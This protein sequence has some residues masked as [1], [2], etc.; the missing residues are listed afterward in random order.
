VNLRVIGC[1]GSRLEES[2]L[3]TMLLGHRVMLDAGSACSVPPGIQ[4]GLDM[5]LLTHAHLDHIL[6]LG[7]LL[8]NV[9]GFRNRPLTV[10]GSRACISIIR[11]HYMNDRLWP[12]FSRISTDGGPVLQY[13]EMPDLEWFQ[14]PEGI[15]AMSVPVNHPAGAR[16]FIFRSRNA[17]MAYS[18]DTG[19]TE[20]IWRRAAEIPELCMAWV[21]C[22]FPDRLRDLA[23]AS[24]H[25]CP[26]LARE[27]M[28]LLGRPDVKCFAFHLKKRLR[29]E[30]VAGLGND[31]QIPENGDSFIL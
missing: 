31:F 10:M 29:E 3:V 4:D 2:R 7:F 25:L 12:D 17:A 21:E 20:E 8:D 9:S 19:P 1:E 11:E 24:D 16:G 14:L 26:S 18:G 5:V 28:A 13:R 15:A 22:S 27:Q 30:T 23:V 6:E